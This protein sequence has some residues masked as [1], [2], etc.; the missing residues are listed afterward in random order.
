L[1]G[2]RGVS[3]AAPGTSSLTQEASVKARKKEYAG[4]RALSLMAFLVL[5][6]L[7][8]VQRVGELDPRLVSGSVP[9]LR[10]LGHYLVG[11]Y[12]GAA[13]WYR[14]SAESIVGAEPAT[15]WASALR[16]DL[17]RAE[18]LAA[19]ELARQPE[20]VGPVLSLAEVALARGRHGEAL[21][22]TGRVLRAQP[23]DYDA[24]LLTAA[25]RARR[26]EW[27]EALD[28]LKT[29]LRQDR[30][31]RRLSVFLS[32]LELT[33]DLDDLESPPL[34]LL[35][36]LHRYLRFHDA[37]QAGNAVTYAERAIAAGDRPD[38]AW[39]AIAAVRDKQDRR[40]AALQA[41]ERAI[42]LNGGNTAALLGA[43]RL[44]AD[45][46]ELAAE[47]RLLRAAFTATPDDPFVAERMHVTL[48]RKLGDY[49]QALTMERAAVAARPEDARAW[50]RL[51]TV[52]LHLGEA[53]GALQS[54]ERSAEV[55]SLAEAHEGR[56][57]ALRELR[58]HEE[59]AAAYQRAIQIDPS[60]PHAYVGLA[61]VHAGERRYAKALDAY[62]RAYHLGARQV[63][64]VV[65]LCSL[66]YEVGR[67][68][69]A[70][71]CLQNVLTRDPEN[72][73]GRAL[74]EHVRAAAARKPA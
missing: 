63:E 71:G 13:R 67:L 6:V 34:A 66:Y 21:E 33:G 24:L 70:L 29:A 61:V 7:G 1:T 60:R 30:V 42:A 49:R 39:V 32:M 51:G 55:G 53:A 26:S 15:S 16:G 45:R 62:E 9:G 3:L 74:M 38:D 65:E 72:V 18:R 56:G 8:G 31:E 27:A 40:R 50:W 37:A 20:A 54:F 10:A 35:A 23:D 69:P 41:F 22:H 64:Q 68:A 46:G 52:Q 12:A 73:R 4:F 28:A 2:S 47:Y 19:G 59:A 57:Q 43:A 48:T 14:A 58:R 44:R 25:V 11:D 36:H 5:L 17:D